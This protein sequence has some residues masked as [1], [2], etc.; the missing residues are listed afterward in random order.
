MPVS[1]GRPAPA[2]TAHEGDA[3]PR[4]A[5][6]P[7]AGSWATLMRRV[8]AVDVLACPRC[9]SRLRVIATVRDPLA[10]QAIRAPLARA[11]D[12]PDPA[13]PAPVAL[14]SLAASPSFPR[15]GPAPSP[16][17]APAFGAA[18]LHPS[19]RSL[20]SPRSPGGSRG[21]HAITRAPLL[22]AFIELPIAL[23]KAGSPR[24]GRGDQI[25]LCSSFAL[26]CFAAAP[27]TLAAT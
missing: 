23:P 14:T 17:A 11:L 18:P 12:P 6:T 24:V 1:Y 10:G 2:L 4:G 20:P 19:A 21:P 8:C 9:G 22:F 7:G 15:R 25:L 16:G 13:P 26:L 5:G 3:S 27:S